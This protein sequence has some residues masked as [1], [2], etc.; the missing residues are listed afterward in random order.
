M[1][2]DARAPGAGH[3]HLFVYGTLRQ[4]SAA[5]AHLRECERLGDA[6]VPGTL[7]DID[8]RFPAVVLYGGGRV[9]GEVWRCPAPAL[10]RLDEYEGTANGLFRRVAIEAETPAGPIP[11]WT[12]AAGPTLARKLVPASRMSGGE[13]PPTQH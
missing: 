13:W 5:N 11:C 3:F 2:R 1:I 4:G 7:Y 6:T 10:A 12:Y 8:G 9:R